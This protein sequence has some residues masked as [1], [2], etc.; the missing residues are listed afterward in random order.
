MLSLLPESPC[1]IEFDE[2]E[3]NFGDD[4][5]MNLKLETFIRKHKG[6]YF[7]NYADLF[8][9][10]YCFSTSNEEHF[11]TVWRYTIFIKEFPLWKPEFYDLIIPFLHGR[12]MEY[13]FQTL[14]YSLLNPNNLLTLSFSSLLL[15]MTKRHDLYSF[16]PINNFYRGLAWGLSFFFF[17]KP[18][19]FED[20]LS[21]YEVFWKDWIGSDDTIIIIA[22][23]IIR[24]YLQEEEEEDNDDNGKV[25]V[26]Y[27]ELENIQLVEKKTL[28]DYFN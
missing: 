13:N 2:S 10:T 1:E 15:E 25:E 28:E 20:L 21:I 11:A 19:I 24:G 8:F 22:T 7:N 18:Y 23:K 9:N 6:C 5:K 26:D 14:F 3:G 12:Y 27:A 4:Y 16:V 17:K